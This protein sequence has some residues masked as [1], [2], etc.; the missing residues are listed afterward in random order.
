MEVC[1]PCE[2]VGCTQTQVT[3][4]NMRPP[5]KGGRVRVRSPFH[6][7][8]P[9][10]NADVLRPLARWLAISSVSSRLSRRREWR[11][12]HLLQVR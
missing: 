9:H 5:G 7:L 2:Q 10:L 3:K 1:L 11:A 6:H 8:A 12:L 4:A